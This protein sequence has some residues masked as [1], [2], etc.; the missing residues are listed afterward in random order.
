MGRWAIGCCSKG[1]ERRLPCVMN[2]S[3][4]T[5]LKPE[6]KKKEKSNL[7]FCR[8]TIHLFSWICANRKE[9]KNKSNA[10]TWILS[11]CAW[12]NISSIFWFCLQ[13]QWSKEPRKNIWKSDV[14]KKEIKLQSVPES[15]EC[16]RVHYQA[17]VCLAEVHHWVLW[18]SCLAFACR[19]NL[20]TEL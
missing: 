12:W 8:P 18:C 4:W 10:K 6:K 11:K 2:L 15:L 16:N 9:R 14:H 20:V 5:V 7:A 1:G 13:S 3:T 17:Q 19:W